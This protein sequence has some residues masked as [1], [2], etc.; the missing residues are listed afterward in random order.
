M[1]K[2]SSSFD[3]QDITSLIKNNGNLVLGKFAYDENVPSEAFCQSLTKR[4]EELM[5]EDIWRL[6]LIDASGC[7]DGAVFVE[8]SRW[9]SEHFNVKIGK[10]K[11]LFFNPETTLEGRITLLKN[12]TKELAGRH[13]ELLFVRVAVRDTLTVNALEK[14]GAI[15]T[16]ILIS[17]HRDLRNLTLPNVKIYGVKVEE[18]SRENEN[19][20]TRI[21]QNVF[22][23][24]HFHADPFLSPYKSD[25]LHSKWVA[26]CLHSL[27]D[28]VLVAKKDQSI[29]GFITCKIKYLT[30]E[31]V[32]G[33]IDLIGVKNES[34]GKGIGTL[35]VSEALK[36]LYER[37]SSVYVGTQA[38]NIDAMRLYAK[39][40]FKTVYSEATMH[41]WI[42]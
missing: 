29:L 42:S 39:L 36:W 41:L 14:Q 32:Y 22:K 3:F 17:F 13:F 23:L 28:V 33:I 4:L 15:L 20:L 7:V 12:L 31:Y 18:A 40:G 21:A 35:L 30:Q 38:G 11:L 19:T 10:T 5:H 8:W 9:D 2:T 37:A 25:E 26:N 24:D 6:A 27:A 34:R 1:Y 16:D